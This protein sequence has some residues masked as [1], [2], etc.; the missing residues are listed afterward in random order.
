M[1]IQKHSHLIKALVVIVPMFIFFGC[2]VWED[3]TTYFN[4]YYDTTDL[5]HQAED[6]INQQKHELF[7]TDEVAIPPNA[8]Q[9]LVRVVEKCSQI[10]QFHA[11]SIYVDDALLMLGKSFYYQANFQKASRE[12]EELITKQ[13][14]SN[15][16]LETRLW[17]GKTQMH[18]DDYSKG[19]AT[20]N[21]VRSEATKIGRDNLSRDAF[22]EEIKYRITQKDYPGAIDLLKQ[23]L[24]VSKD[25][26]INAEVVYETGLLYVK[27]GDYQSAINSFE[28]VT[29]Y[30][31]EF[32]ILYNTEM[33]LGKTLR[34]SGDNKKSLSIF[35]KMIVQ[36]KYADSLSAIEFQR[37]LT[38]VKLKRFDDALEQFKLVDTAYVRTPYSGLA[39]LNIADL[40]ENHYKNMDSAQSYYNRVVL[41]TA[42]QEDILLARSK[43]DLFKKFRDISSRLDIDKRQLVY[44]KDPEAFVKDSID[45]YSD[46]ANTNYLYAKKDTLQNLSAEN[47]LQNRYAPNGLP[48]ADTTGNFNKSLRDTA[49]SNIPNSQNPNPI[50]NQFTNQVPGQNPNQINNQNPNLPGGI[51]PNPISNRF[52]NQPNG[53]NPYQY[54]QNP[55]QYTSNIVNPV[56]VIHK[57]P[58]MRPTVSAD[59]L[60]NE[61]IKLEYDKGNLLFSEFNLP[62]TAL[63]YYEDILSN[64]PGS[65]YQGRTLYALGEYYLTVGDSV[66]ADSLFTIVYNN[67]KDENIVNAAADKLQK[68][69]I[70]FNSGPLRI[71][72][73]EGE[74][75]LDSAKYDSSYKTF[76][77]VYKS[78]PVGTLASR[79]LYASGWI[80]ENKLNLL[81][82]AAVIYDTLAKK[83]PGSEYSAKILQKLNLY[84]QENEKMEKAYQ[85]SVK[86][87][88]SKGD[89]TKFKRLSLQKF[90]DAQNLAI[91]NKTG[92]EALAET[93]NAMKRTPEAKLPNALNVVQPNAIANPDTLIRVFN[94]GL[95]N[96][97][98]R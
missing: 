16:I 14:N 73:E 25:G 55:N 69:F 64:H 30:S 97:S 15:L 47:K 40:Y 8:N 44:I 34:V 22:I 49:K 85:D 84:N 5:F 3:F 88:A 95:L 93:N 4:L 33:D 67:Y 87:Y 66:K 26:A 51:N 38:L 32:N 27:L 20:L 11:K 52:I 82:S 36:D 72:Y 46:T 31:P 68:P 45:F 10:L 50:N 19:L 21:E 1:Q 24:T 75:Y 89:S 62:D 53:Q 56:E 81:D 65:E 58:P 61:I 39:R 6:A 59:T 9:L 54:N 63:I 60:N 80:L 42:P 18:L 86:L 83:F 29:K 35:E 43:V 28:L 74:K 96:N 78:N 77:D 98:N 76:Y 79:A 12:L 41:S 2:G 71:K 70:D 90:E 37:G 92:T 7:S 48:L 57:K 13:P 94:R 91:L 17:L 23:F